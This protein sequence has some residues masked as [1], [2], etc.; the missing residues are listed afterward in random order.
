MHV[1]DWQ[2]HAF[3]SNVAAED[4]AQSLVGKLSKPGTAGSVSVNQSW[5]TNTSGDVKT[6][7]TSA[8]KSWGKMGAMSSLIGKT[9]LVC[10]RSLLDIVECL[11]RQLL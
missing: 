1:V 2:M 4:T 8:N 7:Q 9:S 6:T 5:K 10:K 11:T 3:Y